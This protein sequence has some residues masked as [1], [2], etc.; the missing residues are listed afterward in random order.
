MTNREKKRVERAIQRAMKLENKLY[1]M[2]DSIYKLKC[3][4]HQLDCAYVEHAYS[5][6]EVAQQEL[7]GF[8]ERARAI[9]K[10]EKPFEKYNH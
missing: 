6:I 9:L 7:R 3:G 4:D 10:G 1:K 8:I 2:F 5:G